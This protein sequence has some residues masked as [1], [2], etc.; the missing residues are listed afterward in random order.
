MTDRPI[1]FSAPMVNALLEGRK[2][3]TRRVLKPK[4][5]FLG[6]AGDWDDAEEWGWEDED[7]GHISV[8]DIRLPC[9]T[10]DRLWVREDED[11]GHISVFDIRLPYITGDRLWVREAIN[12]TSE[13]G[14]VFYR[15]DYEAAHGDSGK[16]L[17]WRPSIH[18]PRWASRLTLTVTDVRMQ[19]LHDITEAD[20]VAEGV[21][22]GMTSHG[23][24]WKAYG[25]KPNCW[26]ESARQSYIRLWESIHGTD[27]WHANPR[28]VALTFTVEKRNIDTGDTP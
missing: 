8:F 5:E 2:T 19:R 6:C 18:M 23:L 22:S 14:D 1:I 9:I 25:D 12:K 7:G 21:E 13:P 20:A 3:Q 4:P 11:G 10:G 26:M 28:V 15:A 27:A 17:G 16:G 24:M